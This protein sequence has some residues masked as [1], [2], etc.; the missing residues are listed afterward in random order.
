MWATVCPTSV[1]RPIG[2]TWGPGNDPWTNG[3]EDYAETVGM[4][5]VQG[6]H[7]LKFGGGY[8]RYTKNQVIG[9]DSEGDYTFNDGWNGPCPT[10]GCASGYVPNTPTGVFTG[11][12]YLDFLMGLA[13]EPTAALLAI[14]CQSRSTTT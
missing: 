3:A 11:D 1:G 8:N 10:S 13:Y 5:V 9:K 4:S 2:T 6:K 7:N 14:E 12:S